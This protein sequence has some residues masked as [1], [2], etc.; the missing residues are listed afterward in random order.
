[1]RAEAIKFVKANRLTEFEASLQTDFYELCYQ[2]SIAKDIKS[3]ANAAEVHFTTLYKWARFETTTPRY[4]TF[5]K[6]AHA[7]GYTIR[8]TKSKAKTTTK[9]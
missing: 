6:V 9:H 2:L 1:M 7:L 8:L 4:T 3:I 5:C